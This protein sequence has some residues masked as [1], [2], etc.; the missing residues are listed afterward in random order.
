MMKKLFLLKTVFIVLLLLT[1]FIS[2][3]LVLTVTPTTESCTSNG[4]LSWTISGQTSGSIVSYK[5]YK[6]PNF[7]TPIAST[8]SMSLTGLVAGTYRVTALE[9]IGSVT[10]QTSKDAI[11]T[12]TIKNLVYT[13]TIVH[14]VCG[15]DGKIT[16]NVTQGTPVTYELL[17]GPVIRPPQASNVFTGLPQGIY[18]VRV[19]DACGNA[20]SQSVT[21]TLQILKLILLQFSLFL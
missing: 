3:Q 6:S 13:N 12:N 11:I 14:E 4:S 19:T 15:N 16:V 9:T 20:V 18:T 8:S 1:N 7:T 17:T 21:N 5:I 10:T 2:A